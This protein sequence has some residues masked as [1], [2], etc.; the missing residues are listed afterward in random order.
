LPA[1][2][3]TFARIGLFTFGGGYAMLP[4]ITRAVAGKKQWM[5]EEE[6]LD[7]YTAAQC[8]PGI[9]AVNIV[10]FIGVKV[11][12]APGAVAAALGMIFPSV[13]IITLIAA[14]LN[15]FG[16]NPT[17]QSAFAGIRI[18]ACATITVAVVKLGVK[19]IKN[20]ATAG[21]AVLA[22]ALTALSVVSPAFIAIGAGAAG[23]LYALVHS[24]TRAEK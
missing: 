20:I 16:D 19:A 3:L 4:F 2:F 8:M 18:A 17:I 9:M 15:S 13:V 11:K 24:R 21:I 23:V 7:I 1:L 12:G 22:F 14:S 6:L 10:S 5:S